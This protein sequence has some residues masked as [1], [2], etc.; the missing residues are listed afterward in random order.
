MEFGDAIGASRHLLN[1]RCD[2]FEQYYSS[3]RDER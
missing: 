3:Q 1:D 2:F